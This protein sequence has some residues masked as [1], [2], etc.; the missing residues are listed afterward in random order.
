MRFGVLLALGI[1]GLGYFY[2]ASAPQV[3]FHALRE[4]LGSRFLKFDFIK[5]ILFAATLSSLLFALALFPVQQAVSGHW[6]RFMPFLAVVVLQM[7]LLSTMRI[8]A[9]LAHYVRLSVK[10]AE[11]LTRRIDYGL[12]ADG[13]R[14]SKKEIRTT[15]SEFID[16]YRVLRDQG[17][18]FSV[19]ILE[20][21]LA[22]ALGGAPSFTDFS[23]LILTWILPGTIAWFLGTYLELHLRD[24]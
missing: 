13:E 10:R 2:L 12:A 17:N 14:E 24:S 21:V 5:W 1:A 9:I 19:V 16:S 6:L 15:E 11:A 18:L 4:C 23:L 3:L 7:V 20:A 22:L 8:E